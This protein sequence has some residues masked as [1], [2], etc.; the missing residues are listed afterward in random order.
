VQ[1]PLATESP[2]ESP[3][4]RETPFHAKLNILVV[5]DMI[6]IVD[7]MEIVLERRGHTVYTASSGLEAL[8]ILREHKVDLVFCDLDMPGINGWD[9]GREVRILSEQRGTAK[10]SFVLMTGWRGQ[11]IEARKIMDSGIDGIL[12]KPIEIRRLDDAIRKAILP[13]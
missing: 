6:P 10:T 2:G 3:E 7:M 4:T 11:T 12:E 8:D 9:L 13:G 1:L 5:D